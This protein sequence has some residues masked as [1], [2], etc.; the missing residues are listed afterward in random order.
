LPRSEACIEK[1]RANEHLDCKICP[2]A[3]SYQLRSLP[4]I[5]DLSEDI[6]RTAALLPEWAPHRQR[7]A[8]TVTL[9]MHE[10]CMNA[11]EHGLLG[12]CKEEKKR[13]MEEMQER[14]IAYVEERW[15]ASCTPIFV[16]VCFNPDRVLIG[17]HDDGL[18]FDFNLDR[19]STID[20]S[21]LMDFSGRGLAILKGMNIQLYWN[22]KGN[23][24]LCSFRRPDLNQ[25]PN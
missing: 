23:S 1:H 18:G 22:K 19:F 16:S 10:T 17:V 7:L 21:S 13:L 25:A 4:Q 11:V 24:V 2:G 9:T 3:K 12:L 5:N 6:I 20:E 14:Y 8:Y 15:K